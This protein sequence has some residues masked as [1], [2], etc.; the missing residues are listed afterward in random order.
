MYTASRWRARNG[1]T[2]CS[3]AVRSH[4]GR[5]GC[6]RRRRPGHCLRNQSASGCVAK[7][8]KSRSSRAAS[9][10]ICSAAYVSPPPVCADTAFTSTR[11]GPLRTVA[12]HLK[13]PRRATVPRVSGKRIG[14]GLLGCGGIASYYHLPV[15]AAHPG[16]RVVAVADPAETA[17]SRAASLVPGIVAE[18]DAHSV[19]ER[20]DVDA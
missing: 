20:A 18:L 8:V 16:A 11:R 4:T 2:A 1:I 14:I 3:Q 10:G 5:L 12:I 13:L 7:T 19:L 9:S 6:S 15:L 17:R